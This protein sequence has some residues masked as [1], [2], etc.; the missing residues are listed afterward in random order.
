MSEIARLQCLGQT[1]TP[2]SI[3]PE[4]ASFASCIDLSR[5]YAIKIDIHAI[6][7]TAQTLLAAGKGIDYDMMS[8]H[9]ARIEQI[10]L[11]QAL[12]SFS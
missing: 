3:V 6:E 5:A 11:G 7:G 12:T 10:G 4:C 2:P 8:G 1:G 9:I